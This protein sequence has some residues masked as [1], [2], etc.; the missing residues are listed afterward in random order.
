MSDFQVCDNGTTNGAADAKCSIGT[1]NITV[2]SVNDAPVLAAVS[3]S[4]VLLGNSL[5]FTA[6]AKDVDLPAD[7][8][9]FSLVGTVPGGASIN[10]STGAFSWTPTAAQAGQIYNLTIRVTDAGGLYSE[11]S[12]NVG[13]AYEWSN[14]LAPVAADGSSVFNTGRTVPIQFILTGAS[15]PVTTATAK[16][17]LA[18]VTNGVVGTEFPAT[19][20]GG[21]NTGNLFRYDAKEG[22]YIFNLSTQNLTAG[23]Y[24]LR[25]DL[26]D[27]VSRT[28]LITLR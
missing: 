11:K 2:N 22:Q 15:Q 16:L 17:Y 25:I 8:L 14:L 9:T 5:V 27:G 3:N 12:F 20:V 1:V 19:A 10:P 18:T 4:V 26:G 24:Q 7:T 23:T 21:S 6:S 13:V 28:V